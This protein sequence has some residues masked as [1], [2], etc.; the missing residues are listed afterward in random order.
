[1][2]IPEFLCWKVTLK[3][4][5][6]RVKSRGSFDCV[7]GALAPITGRDTGADNVKEQD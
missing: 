5:L 7:K 2:A 3:S 1:M 4:H 6:K